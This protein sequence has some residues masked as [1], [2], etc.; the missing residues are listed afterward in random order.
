MPIL[1]SSKYRDELLA[2]MGEYGG[3]DII[4]SNPE[5]ISYIDVEH[6]HEVFDF[7]HYEEYLRCSEKIR[8]NR[9]GL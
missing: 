6:L 2:S 8:G 1:F 7:N 9:D 4:E 3:F 5:D